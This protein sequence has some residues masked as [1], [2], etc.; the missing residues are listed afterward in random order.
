MIQPR[1]KAVVAW[2]RIP[3]PCCAR[4]QWILS[5]QKHSLHQRMNPFR[6]FVRSS[7]PMTPALRLARTREGFH[8]QEVIASQQL[9]P[10]FCK[11]SKENQRLAPE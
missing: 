11:H 9:G 3:R 5:V 4:A 2:G 10:S 8:L 7:T 6:E 1:L